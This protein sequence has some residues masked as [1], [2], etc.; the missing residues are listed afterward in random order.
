MKINLGILCLMLLAS[1]SYAQLSELKLEDIVSKT[2][3]NNLDL[4]IASNN[5]VVAKNLATKEQAGYLPTV[6]LNGTANYSNNN[7]N[8]EFAGGL[9][10][11][12]VNGAVNTGYG[13]NVGVNYVVF[14]GFTR[15]NNY[16][17]LVN[18]SKLTDI[19][20]KVLSENLVFDA[21]NRYLDIQ[22][23][24]LDL[25]AA[26]DNLQIS[27]DRVQ[28]TKLANEN[29]SKS[30]LDVLSATVDFNNDS[31]A[32]TTLIT[33]IEKQKSSLSVLMGIDPSTP[34]FLSSDIPIPQSQDIEALTETALNNN[35]TILLAKVATNLAEINTRALQGQR[36]PQV[37]LSMS[38]GL[39]ENQNGAGIVL[40]QKTLGFNGGLS[41]SI[42]IY[43]G[44]QLK[45]ALIN[46][47]I[48]EKTSSL[49]LGK[50]ILTI[51]NEMK[52]AQLDKELLNATIGA[53]QANL[54][55]AEL[56][57]ERA[58]L[59]Y[60][61]GQISFNDLRMAQLQVLLSKNS[62][63]QSNINLIRLYYAVNRLSGG[64]I[65]E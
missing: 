17:A 26:Y 47:E 23:S 15:E 39:Q 34:Y 22:Q 13:A 2:L 35:A 14:N 56:A 59:A 41:L 53:Q 4:A 45:T 60:N 37:G 61:N 30:K 58:K 10:P 42:P 16:K 62:L 32:V 5:A 11:V 29:G 1:T 31:L 54:S 43:N 48:A 7:T 57:L 49:E 20:F 28:R 12:E 52:A 8:L 65:S 33:N 36:L 27:K 38:Y 40:V 46:S 51:Q 6:S 21:V 18:S 3:Q 55:L 9:P 63:N 19:Q 25:Q 24:K 64:L 50:A 44:S